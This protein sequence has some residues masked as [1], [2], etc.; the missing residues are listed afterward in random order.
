MQLLANMQLLQFGFQEEPGE[1]VRDIN[2]CPK[3]APLPSCSMS[4]RN[5]CKVSLYP[6]TVLW[7]VAW[8]SGLQNWMILMQVK[9]QG[10]PEDHTFCCRWNSLPMC[11]ISCQ[12][13]AMSSQKANPS[14]ASRNST[15]DKPH[16]EVGDSIAEF[17]SQ[18]WLHLVILHLQTH[19]TGYKYR[20]K[21]FCVINCRWPPLEHYGE[22]QTIRSTLRADWG[23][24]LG[25]NTIAT[26]IKQHTSWTTFS[27]MKS[28]DHS[29]VLNDPK[30]SCAT[31]TIH[32]CYN[33]MQ[34]TKSKYQEGEVLHALSSH[35]LYHYSSCPSPTYTPVYRS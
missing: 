3:G 6:V 35:V 27:T 25:C 16:L 14:A 8:I 5:G 20:H 1:P 13:L 30:E 26:Q 24:T 22:P 10:S 2:G 23:P 11:S 21:E 19:L 33:P 34:A 7:K 32:E 31:A 15:T 9:S 18:W 17:I 12:K 4:A 29:L 28:G